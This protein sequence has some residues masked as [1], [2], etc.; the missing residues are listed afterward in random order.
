MTTLAI[1]GGTGSGLYPVGA[2]AD[3]V[4]TTTRWGAPSAPLLRWQQDE[5]TVLFLRR[6]GVDNALPPHAVNYRANIQLLA[7]N[8]ADWVLASNAVGGIAPDAAPGSV[9]IPAQLV[10]YTWGREHSFY[11]GRGGLLEHIDMTEPFDTE[12]RALLIAAADDAGVPCVP[13]GTYGVTQGPRLETPAEI[14]RLER[15]GCS[16]VGMTAMPE[17]GLAREAGLRYASCC[18]VVN[19]AAGR[20]DTDIH[21]EIETWVQQAMDN[22]TALVRALLRRI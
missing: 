11:D 20:S 16:I 14:D 5:H 1:I 9:V 3:A 2:A 10:D 15:D 17:A 19:I 13:A 7:D 4:T 21:A 6:H 12:L 8:G 18:P 22:L